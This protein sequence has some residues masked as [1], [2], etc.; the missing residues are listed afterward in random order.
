MFS[1]PTLAT[2][3]QLA[4]TPVFLL[5]A[6]GSILNVLAARLARVIDRARTIEASMP[7]PGPARARAV[8]ELIALDRR[9]RLANRAVTLCVCSGLAA[10]LL[11]AALFVAADT[12]LPASRIVP[13]L[14]V[15]VMALVIAG[16]ATF[17]LEIRI[18]TR[19][20]R[21]KTELITGPP[22]G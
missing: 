2:A 15:I 7:P 9:M 6:V 17:L 4:L 11:I 13:A 10:C 18:A 21:V 20:L 12:S 1:G 22:T 19:T 3:I 8:A 14:F 5:T 16:L